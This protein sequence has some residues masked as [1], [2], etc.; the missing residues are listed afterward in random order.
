MILGPGKWAGRGSFRPTDA[1]LG[2]RFQA[3]VDIDDHR[4]TEG[5]IVN[6]TIQVD[7]EVDQG[8]PRSILV[9]IVPDEVGTYSVTVKGADI[10]VEG[11]AKL[12]S[13][14][15]LGLL[16]SEDG[17]VYVTCTVFHAAG[18]PRRARVCEGARHHVDL[19][20]SVT[21]GASR[22]AAP[23]TTANQGWQSARQRG[24]AHRP[25]EALTAQR[26]SGDPGAP[27]RARG[28]PPRQ[29]AGLANPG[30]HPPIEGVPYD[31]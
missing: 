17:T 16:W 8:G 20:A 10:D 29:G 6:A 7:G 5:L 24:F 28:R 27:A 12:D 30:R 15:H 3:T 19:G 14:P 26:R 25:A 2:I 13:E 1:S 4:G 31:F 22:R 23:A 21:A 18:D 11:T 9:W